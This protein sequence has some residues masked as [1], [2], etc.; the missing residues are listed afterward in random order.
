MPAPRDSRTLR[1]FPPVFRADARLL[2]LGSMPGAESLRRREYYAHPRNA[3]W[4]IM[5]ALI[6]ARPEQPYRRRITALRAA[7]VA[8]WDVIAQCRRA[9]SRD[10]AIVP[11][12]V[13]PNDIE[14]LLRRAPG[15]R[16]I[17]FNGGGAEHWFFRCY[18]GRLDAPPFKGLDFVRLPSTSP[19]CATLTVARKIRLWRCALRLR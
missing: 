8:L 15:L 1:S 2:I 4:P 16:R 10:T 14:R 12:S 6:G 18:R 5:G 11:E 3:F 17:L 9:G 19:A 7:R 13:I